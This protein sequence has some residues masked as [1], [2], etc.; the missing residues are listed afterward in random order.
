MVICHYR[1]YQTTPKMKKIISVELLHKICKRLYPSYAEELLNEALDEDL[2]YNLTFMKGR[3][4]GEKII[5]VFQKD[6]DYIKWCSKSSS[7]GYHYPEQ[8]N[9]AQSLCKKE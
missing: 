1:K 6:P 3:Y 8:A 2:E 5:D 7:F 9:V 4:E